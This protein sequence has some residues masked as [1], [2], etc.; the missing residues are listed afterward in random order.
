MFIKSF[1]EMSFICDPSFY[2]QKR[3]L[4]CE[5]GLEKAEIFIL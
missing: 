3:C 5:L 4:F 1:Q 2:K